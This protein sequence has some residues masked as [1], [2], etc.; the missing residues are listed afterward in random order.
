[1]TAQ[2]AGERRA[3]TRIYAL[4]TILAVLVLVV[5]YSLG[6][7]ERESARMGS[8][9]RQDAGAASAAEEWAGYAADAA[10]IYAGAAMRGGGTAGGRAAGGA[11]AAG[12]VATTPAVGAGFE[13]GAPA[14]LPSDPMLIRTASLRLRVEDVAKAHE[15][16]GRIAAEADGYVADTTL[17]AETGPSSATITIRVP[18]RGLESVMD[19]V[20]T[21][22]K[23][24]EK[25]INTQEVSEEY[26][27]L[28]SRKRN[29][30]RE[31]QQLLELLKRAGKIPELL[32][33]EQTLARVRGEVERIAGRMRYLENR[34]ALSAVT[35]RLEGP[36]PKPTAG[37]PVW[38]ASDVFRQATR[39]LIRTGRGLATIGIWLGV[40]IPVWLP[41]LVV[42][43]LVIRR[44]SAPRREPQ[45]NTGS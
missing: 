25:R 28:G 44:A 14:R 38:A 36:E 29:L 24:L 1:M 19:R 30:E 12:T 45:T 33:V 15:E 22:G 27:D 10:G 3:R 6:K 18:S 5:A 23:L 9:P 40:Y 17:N 20:V 41:I 31:E 42:L 7:R 37:G 43:A 34:V 11:V 16:V 39:S 4:V 13:A 8:A 2:T 32:Q 26:V 35:V 21:L